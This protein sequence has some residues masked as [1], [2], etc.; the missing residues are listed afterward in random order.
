MSGSLTL[1]QQRRR[2]KERRLI[3]SGGHDGFEIMQFRCNMYI[4]DEI[5]SYI[6]RIEDID[7]EINLKST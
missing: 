3:V 5:D 2:R 4:N 1:G 7:I 6:P